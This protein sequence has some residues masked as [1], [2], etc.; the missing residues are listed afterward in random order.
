MG[1]KL[2]S[3]IERT[4]YF[5]EAT[6]SFHETN[7][8]WTVDD[9]RSGGQFHK[10]GIEKGW[11]VICIDGVKITQSNFAH[12]LETITSEYEGIL[13]FKIPHVIFNF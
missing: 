2:W 3:P 10:H 13:N 6:L 7:L 4:S 8:N 9:V 5:F 1:L 11:I 12:S